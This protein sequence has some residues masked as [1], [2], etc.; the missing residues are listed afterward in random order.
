VNQGFGRIHPSL[1]N[2]VVERPFPGRLQV[3]CPNLVVR[4]DAWQDTYFPSSIR[5]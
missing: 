4:K 3:T 2:E 5:G 1:L